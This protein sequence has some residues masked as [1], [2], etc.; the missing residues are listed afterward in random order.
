MKK[1]IN[2]IVFIFFLIISIYM[3]SVKKMEGIVYGF[4]NSVLFVDYIGFIKRMDYI[5]IWIS[6]VKDNVFMVSIIRR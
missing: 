5:I 3:I 1:F 6:E 4:F 2:L